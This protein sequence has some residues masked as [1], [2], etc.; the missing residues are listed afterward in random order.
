MNAVDRESMSSRAIARVS[1]ARPHG[2][3]SAGLRSLLLTLLLTF[4]TLVPATAVHGDELDRV[5]P[6]TIRVCRMYSGSSRSWYRV[7][8]ITFREYVKTVLPR[9]FPSR[10]NPEALKAGATAIRS[11]AWFWLERDDPRLKGQCD[12][13]DN[14]YWQVYKP[15]D[16]KNPRT[17]LTDAI[18]DEMWNIRLEASNGTTLFAQYCASETLYACRNFP[19]GKFI[20]QIQARQKAD[21]GWTWDAIVK[22]YYRRYGVR[23]IDWTE[24]FDLRF[25][26]TISS[27]GDA[28]I[29]VLPTGVLDGDERVEGLLYAF[30]TI[31]GVPGPHEVGRVGVT[32]QRLAFPTAVVDTCEEHEFRVDAH[33]AIKGAIAASTIGTAWRPWVAAEPREVSRLTDTSDP[34]AGSVAI[35][36]AVFEDAVAPAEAD[37][38]VAATIGRAEPVFETVT[39]TGSSAPTEPGRARAAV[40]ARAD[41][42]A[43]A[44]SATGLAGPDAPILLNPGG[45]DATLA[46]AIEA[47]LGRILVAGQRVHVIGGTAAIPERV[48]DRLTEL[49]YEVARHAGADRVRTAV[50]VATAIEDEFGAPEAVMVARAWPNTSAG[51]ADATAGGAYAASQRWPVLLTPTGSLSARVEDYIEDRDSIQEVVLVGGPKAVPADAEERLDVTTTRVAG[52]DRAATATAIADQLWTRADAPEVTAALIVDVYD[53]RDWPFALAS[54]VYAA[55]EGTPQIA[56][57]RLV[58]RTTSG[59]WLDANAELPAVVAGGPAVVGPTA[60][61]HVAGDSPGS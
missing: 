55:A 22:H 2:Q 21:Q 24:P 52:A 14:T 31:D 7:D 42:F 56:V 50:A 23:L 45:P 34:V 58:P 18:V 54:A 10:W 53:D 17:E 8:T 6:E 51:W 1:P 48:T 15:E 20:P 38:P 60:E 27:T 30:C 61:A 47:E 25:A 59:A 29:D 26:R 3:P 40:I 11:Y 46:P 4:V 32:D 16:R 43:D 13:G 28:T 39:D 41:V 57:R 36:R 35:S 19:D 37:D 44:L 5:P 49:G 12:I 33:L 9:E